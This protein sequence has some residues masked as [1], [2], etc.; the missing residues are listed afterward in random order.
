MDLLYTLLAIKESQIVEPQVIKKLLFHI[1]YILLYTEYYA[2]KL[3]QRG[4]P[5][6]GYDHRVDI[7]GVGVLAFE[8]CSGSPPFE[9]STRDKI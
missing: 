9:S 3:C 4:Y 6:A 7:W 1:I 8:L 5:R 2:P